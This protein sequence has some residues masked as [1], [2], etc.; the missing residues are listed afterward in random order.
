[1]LQLFSTATL[2]TGFVINHDYYYTGKSLKYVSVT[3]M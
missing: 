1:M 3:Y 2:I